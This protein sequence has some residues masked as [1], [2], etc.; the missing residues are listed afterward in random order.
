MM[1]KKILGKVLV[2]L[3]SSKLC[4]VELL[5]TISSLVLADK[6]RSILLPTGPGM[7]ICVIYNREL[8]TYN[9]CFALNFKNR[10]H[11]FI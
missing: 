7:S 4:T 2:P 6:R 5:L 11:I 9:L 3:I 8:K 10:T 1:K